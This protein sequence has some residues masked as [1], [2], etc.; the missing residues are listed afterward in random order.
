LPPTLRSEFDLTTAPSAQAGSSIDELAPVDGIDPRL[1]RVH[2]SL[3]TIGAGS[4][5]TRGSVIVPHSGGDPA[6]LMSGIYARAGAESHLLAAPGWRA[7]RVQDAALTPVRRLLDLRAAVLRQEIG[8]RTGPIEALLFCSLARPRVAV[9]RAR[10]PIHGPRVVQTLEP[11]PG[12]ACE[13]GE[14]DGATW[15]RATSRPAAIVAA[16]HG[17][18]RGSPPGPCARPGRGI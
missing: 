3:L 2:K 6:V 14:D 5:E 16:L 18:L 1:V 17:R 11:P 10:G 15:I 9:L 8:V 4:L 13:Q 12:V 7:V